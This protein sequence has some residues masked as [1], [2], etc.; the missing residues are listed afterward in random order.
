MKHNFTKFFLILSISS[1]LLVFLVGASS[2]NFA[3]AQK[4]QDSNFLE[5]SSFLIE[6]T[7]WDNT[8]F[9]EEA[10]NILQKKE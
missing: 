8:R 5:Q 7:F 9:C 6:T 10:D 2:V 3:F 4:N 1:V